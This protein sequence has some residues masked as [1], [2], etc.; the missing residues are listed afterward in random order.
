MLRSRSRFRYTLEEDIPLSTSLRDLSFVVVD[1]E[2]TGFQVEKEDRLIEIGAVGIEHLQVKEETAFQSYIN[3]HRSIPA[4]IEQL[5]HITNDHVDDAPA[6]KE[7]IKDFFQYVETTCTPCL[8]GHNIGFDVT[9]FKQELKRAGYKIKKPKV[10]DTLD[11]I[12]TVRPL[13]K[14][15]DL[16]EYADIFQ[17][18][19]VDRHTAKGDALTTAYLFCELVNQLGKRGYHTWGDLLQITESK[20]RRKYL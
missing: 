16:E 6:A 3:P 11:L 13:L 17:T 1:T 19:L 15:K 7:V 10:I 9:V 14:G 18:P 20:H 8:V 2:T 4:T 12:H 5:T